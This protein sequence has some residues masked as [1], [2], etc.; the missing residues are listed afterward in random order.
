M[1]KIR[2]YI[3]NVGS[4]KT[5]AMYSYLLQEEKE[6]LYHS[7]SRR[8]I[9]IVPEQY[10]MQA[11]EN[12]L[13]IK[14][15][16]DGSV[17]V[18][19]SPKIYSFKR[20]AYEILDK[21]S[22]KENRTLDEIAKIML[23][24][25]LM[26][27][28]VDKDF[29]VDNRISNLSGI[30]SV[31]SEFEQYHIL[32]S[33]IE[34]VLEDLDE[35][36]PD[37]KRL[38]FLK[39]IY[40]D[41]LA[42]IGEQ[43]I[44]FD[45]L[46][47]AKELLKEKLP[48]Q[49][50]V[51]A[52]DEFNGFT[53][54]QLDFIKE[55][56]DQ[57]DELLFTLTLPAVS[58]LKNEGSSY[59]IR[60]FFPAVRTYS[61]LRD[62][63]GSRKE[64]IILCKKGDVLPFP[65][66]KAE[67]TCR[68]PE[69]SNRDA[70]SHLE[71]IERHYLRGT[72]PDK[73]P[74][75]D[76]VYLLKS[77]S[78]DLEI[79]RVCEEILYLTRKKGY[80]YKDIAVVSPDPERYKRY[81]ARMKERYGIPFLVDAGRS[82]D[83]HPL[84]FL[85]LQALEVIRTDF[86][87]YSVIKLMKNPLFGVMDAEEL[88][89]HILKWGI[90]G[91]SRFENWKKEDTEAFSGKH[92]V[93]RLKP[94]TDVFKTARKSAKS[95]VSLI[96]A[97]LIE[98][99]ENCNPEEAFLRL[100][101]SQNGQELLSAS[102]KEAFYK[103]AQDV[104]ELISESM[105]KMERLL[106]EEEVTVEEYKEILASALASSK[107]GD[108][109]AFYDGVMMKDL[110]FSRHRREYR[111]VFILGMNEGSLPVIPS[112]NGLFTESLR[113]SFAKKS[114][115]LSDNSEQ[116]I[117]LQSYELYRSLLMAKERL[118]L[119]CPQ[120]DALNEPLR[121]S[122][123][124][125]ELLDLMDIR[126]EEEAGFCEK[127]AKGGYTPNSLV[128]LLASAQAEGEE[129]E[130]V[131]ALP[132]FLKESI[133]RRETGEAKASSGEE[134]LSEWERELERELEAFEEGCE[135]RKRNPVLPAQLSRRMYDRKVFSISQM[136]NFAG[137]H[138]AHFCKY[139]LRLKERQLYLPNTM[140][141]GQIL[142]SS[143]EYAESEIL[144]QNKK[145]RM[146][147]EE[148][149]EK[150]SGQALQYAFNSKEGRGRNEYLNYHQS[151]LLRIVRRSLQIQSEQMRQGSFELHSFEKEFYLPLDEERRIRGVIDRIDTF[152]DMVRVIDYKSGARELDN[153]LIYHGLQLQLPLYLK[154][155][156]RLV[157]RERAD[158]AEPAV[159][160][161]GMFYY[162]LYDPFINIEKETEQAKGAPLKEEFLSHT[163]RMQMRLSGRFNMNKEHLTALDYC[164]AGPNEGVLEGDYSSWIIDAKTKKNGELS[165]FSLKNCGIGPE[166]IMNVAVKNADR[167][168]DEILEGRILINPAVIGQENACT[169]CGY[170]GICGM[171]G[172]S[173][174]YRYLRKVTD[175]EFLLRG[176]EAF[177]SDPDEWRRV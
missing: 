9:V 11:Q 2:Y 176:K 55:L 86:S 62:S 5:R 172:R 95:K 60:L 136:E 154:G 100:F 93:E 6:S 77:L 103:E 72:K 15:K 67:G 160:P 167:I 153:S 131:K 36:M 33:D 120:S 45:L 61:D 135:E 90:R 69:S 52:F 127:M 4:G 101:C 132:V 152:K 23:L 123:L 14:G 35:T 159:S 145:F 161:N 163:R 142:H 66:N 129:V 87:D 111:A 114:L 116:N 3:G 130:Q 109:P 37:Y 162:R 158:M 17:A 44:R 151:K 27:K 46:V 40:Q 20:L 34:S 12:L 58:L 64:E 110:M 82:I 164:F 56:F 1:A 148:D 97:A 106:G 57:A 74:R 144:R 50:A 47:P 18:V 79:E 128:Y 91:R 71:V 137:C 169:Y 80:Q 125:T 155:A 32:P 28:R 43:D 16:R 170:K 118:Y 24:R 26:K 49:N 19:L 102:E 173:G 31:L 143:M 98:V 75:F 166:V 133:K 122:Y 115:S 134:G 65:L 149:I 89:N 48:F 81:V 29:I 39:G 68:L 22:A 54:S 177:L 141:Y 78:V 8:N 105:E 174:S 119:S 85:L 42:Y 70:G 53:R 107:I 171:D 108:I 146:L 113:Q 139:G 25:R 117:M 168:T 30:K 150:M 88:E 63:F 147:S 92:P 112:E 41:Y 138:F 38:N 121:A 51:V 126:V 76:N 124:L 156:M 73:K 165:A 13:N 7:G 175:E 59:D 96:N 99:W 140:D 104:S 10:A 94:L 84:S 83:K 21:Y 157:E